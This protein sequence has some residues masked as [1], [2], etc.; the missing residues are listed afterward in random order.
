MTGTHKGKLIFFEGVDGC[1][2]TVQWHKA[3]AA[4]RWWGSGQ[5]CDDN[6]IEMIDGAVDVVE[7]ALLF[8]GDCR[9][10]M[11][12]NAQLLN[13][14]QHVISDRGP[15][16]MMAYQGTERDDFRFENLLYNLN[17][18]AME[19]V[20]TAATIVFHAPLEVCIERV[21]HRHDCTLSQKAIDEM[22]RAHAYYERISSPAHIASN[23]RIPWVGEV[24]RVNSNLSIEEVHQEV[25]IIL[26]KIFEGENYAT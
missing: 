4:T 6:Y 19:E 2:K 24:Y 8:A 7:R 18:W 1:G 26:T 15:L 9:Q 11:H 12:F 3:I 23:P 14:G 10:N 25:M 20:E 5:P 17:D 21:Q 22:T 13:D 16:S